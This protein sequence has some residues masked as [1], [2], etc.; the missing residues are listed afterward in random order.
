MTTKLK[1]LATTI[2]AGAFNALVWAQD[3]VD[4]PTKQT[5]K[6]VKETTQK[7]A[8]SGGF[9]DDLVHNYTSWDPFKVGWF[10]A[11]VVFAYG[12]ATLFFRSMLDDRGASTASKM[13]CFFGAIAFI[14]IN[15]VTFG[16][17]IVETMN[18]KWIGWAAALVLLI[19]VFLLL[20]SS[21]KVRA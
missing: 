6:A 18:Y 20:N 7:A 4:E 5:G 12:V 21:K 11:T 2:A 14:G 17:I 1:L 3:L 8:T 9:V 15:L 13:G 10:I 19:I 16:L